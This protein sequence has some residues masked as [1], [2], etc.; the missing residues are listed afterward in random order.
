[1]MQALSR[2]SFYALEH[3]SHARAALCSDA[4][5]CDA[6]ASIWPWLFTHLRK[7][8]P[9]VAKDQQQL[10]FYGVCSRITVLGGPV[11]TPISHGLLLAPM[12][13]HQL[14]GST[15]RVTIFPRR[16][17]KHD[18]KMMAFVLEA[19][20][21]YVVERAALDPDTDVVPDCYRVMFD[22][23]K[24]LA[25]H[26]E[27]PVLERSKWVLAARVLYNSGVSLHNS[28]PL[29]AA[30]FKINLI[31]FNFDKRMKLILWLLVI[32]WCVLFA[33]I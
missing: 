20:S 25:G 10:D 11:M 4:W 15:L 2:N 31:K 3:M 18:L 23:L 33:A 1:M 17:W 6:R 19:Q 29:D 5:L 27:D 12:F 9:A 7:D 26:E 8:Y 30:V 13:S 21:S 28:L 32:F 22:E 24:E 14:A 16:D